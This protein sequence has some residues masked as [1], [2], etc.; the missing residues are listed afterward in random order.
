MRNFSNFSQYAHA[1]LSFRA[2]WKRDFP[3]FPV[4][5]FPAN[6]FPPS[7]SEKLATPKIVYVVS[8]TFSEHVLRR[9]RRRRRRPCGGA[10][11]VATV[12]VVYL[13]FTLR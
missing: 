9:R 11:L 8:P 12:P 2:F 13:L 6:R 5:V 10:R 7:E 4:V 3:D 1:R